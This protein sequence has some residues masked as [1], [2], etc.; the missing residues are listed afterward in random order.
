ML[1]VGANSEDLVDEVFHGEDVVFAEV[2][3]DEGVVGQWNALLV[4]LGKATLVDE[5]ANGFEIW[6]TIEGT[7]VSKGS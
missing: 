7:L 1:E 3:L 6:F 2:L 5:F 4:D